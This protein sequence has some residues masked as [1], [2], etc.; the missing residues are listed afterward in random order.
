M[1]THRAPKEFVA[2][3]L[4]DPLSGSRMI[5]QRQRTNVIE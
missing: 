5:Q 3:R 2:H 1:G 4:F